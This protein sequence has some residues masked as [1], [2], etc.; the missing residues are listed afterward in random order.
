M[1]ML[2]ALVAHH[3]TPT[4][5]SPTARENHL[6]RAPFKLTLARVL[7][8]VTELSSATRLETERSI[9]VPDHV[10]TVDRQLF[11]LAD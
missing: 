1:C 7:R 10:A 9:D 4:K 8:F 11:V 2:C 3:K 6:L 5:R